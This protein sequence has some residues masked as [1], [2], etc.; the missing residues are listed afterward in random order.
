MAQREVEKIDPSIWESGT[1]TAPDNEDDF[2]S[3]SSRN[4]EPP[5][6]FEKTAG[7]F[8][9]GVAEDPIIGAALD[10]TGI[11]DDEARQELSRRLEDP[12][13]DVQDV[14]Q[15][16]G[17]LT[18]LLAGGIGAFNLGRR[19]GTE[20]AK[21][22]SPS[23][24]KALTQG[25]VES[26]EQGLTL[27]PFAAQATRAVGG[28]LGIGALET[29]NDL[30]RGKD[31]QEALATGGKAAA[32]TLTGEAVIGGLGR[33][34]ARGKQGA[35]AAVEKNFRES[36]AGQAG[37]DVLSS[38]D[39]AIREADQQV[40]AILPVAD[41]ATQLERARIQAQTVLE[42]ASKK[43][44]NANA[45]LKRLKERGLNPKPKLSPA[46]IEAE[47]ALLLRQLSTAETKA[48][49]LR[50]I[51]GGLDD[52][53]VSSVPGSYLSD[54][55]I[56][57]HASGL[58]AWP[59]LQRLLVQYVKSPETALRQLG[60]TGMKFLQKVQ[61][62]EQRMQASLIYTKKQILKSREELAEALGHPL[63]RTK[64]LGRIKPG[65]DDVENEQ[66]L[67]VFHEWEVGG[68][69][70]LR[71]YIRSLTAS[72]E[73]AEKAVKA[74]QR[75]DKMMTQPGERLFAMGGPGNYTREQLAKQGVQKYVPKMLIPTPDNEATRRLLHDAGF[76]E[77][78]IGKLLQHSKSGIEE[79]GT[80]GLHQVEEMSGSLRDK[81]H[82]I[83]AKVLISDPWDA[84]QRDAL[85]MHK[86]IIYGEFLGV[87][88]STSTPGVINPALLAKSSRDLGSMVS[89]DSVK[90]RIFRQV[91]AEGGDVSLFNTIWDITTGSNF[92]DA[93][94]R[95]LADT[96][97]S[98]QIASKLVYA[99][100]PNLS[101]SLNSGL[102]FGMLNTFKQISNIAKSRSIPEKA[103]LE[104]WGVID[105]VP[106]GVLDDYRLFTTSE[107][108]SKFAN[109][110]NWAAR[111]V[112]DNTGFSAVEK[113]NKSVAA[114]AGLSYF[115]QTVGKLYV[116]RKA[117][118]GAE[119]AKHRRAFADWGLDLD[120]I[121]RNFDNMTP[122]QVEAIESRVAF[123][124]MQ[125]TQFL[126]TPS[127]KP[128]W[129]NSPW[130][131]VV[132]QFKTFAFNQAKLV[133]D[134]VIS[135]AGN[136][137]I[138]PLAQ[139][140][141][142]HP[143]AGEVVNDARFLFGASDKQKT[144]IDRYLDNIMA[145]GGAGLV[146][147]LY[148]SASAGR[149]LESV[150]GPTFSD[151]TRLAQESIQSDPVSATINVVGG[152]P[153]VKAVG[154]VLQ[155]PVF[156]AAMAV[157]YFSSEEEPTPRAGAIRAEDF[158]SSNKE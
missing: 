89:R 50:T 23:I 133:R 73:K 104:A 134:A 155:F 90:E 74:M 120:D 60:V 35:R 141:S 21:R 30:F 43:K 75:M 95:S 76:D 55:P 93:S 84:I 109:R 153:A 66:W 49:M 140:M 11:W 8:A 38:L 130:G 85:G 13:L 36:G 147:D 4:N 77:L 81:A 16:I 6:I 72:P 127:R 143:V 20:V 18:P 139:I 42:R 152:Q 97:I 59:A 33:M 129:W 65:A 91:R 98:S 9:L 39:D 96:V 148:R 115:R 112:M 17:F 3:G 125:Q 71:T 46:D 106:T 14:F 12:G 86:R 124:S 117:W 45:K 32:L 123:Q 131:R 27:L 135:E 110:A 144:G 107:G 2:F 118:V 54:A 101:Q 136:G 83:G 24:A 53:P 154:S 57:Q 63:K 119:L 126:S 146:S 31:I 100:I 15:G 114:H 25:V 52:A 29:T 156:G 99:V 10:A 34:F 151:A 87:A 5:S 69:E 47:E 51:R 105:D 22:V 44:I 132:T 158:F 92:Y 80:R 70:G 28:S 79:M 145:V 41:T 82:Q 48:K 116:N 40:K 62:A 121:V 149:L 128:G 7:A 102:R 150:S 61:R 142:I 108:V 157:D 94:M 26:G 67:D 88:P 56:G 113:F 37:D 1:Q 111:F 19:A 68:E 137:N 58:L 122:A 78:A 138:V 103:K 64:I